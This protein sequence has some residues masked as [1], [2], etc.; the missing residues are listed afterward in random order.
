MA[1]K[2]T[3]SIIKSC[4]IWSFMVLERTRTFSMLLRLA[5]YSE[6]QAASFITMTSTEHNVWWFYLYWSPR[7]WWNLM[8]K[9][10]TLDITEWCRISSIFIL[11]RKG[12]SSANTLSIAISVIL[13]ETETK[14]QSVLSSLFRRRSSLC[15][16]SLWIS[17]WD[18]PTYL[19]KIL[20]GQSRLITVTIRYSQSP[21]SPRN[22]YC[23][24]QA[25]QPTPPQTRV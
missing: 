21:T 12:I 1:I 14:D 11:N 2:P 10:I 7:S 3:I 4:R 16:S 6:S 5:T 23:W 20:C 17:S 18:C 13:I 25:T 22:I 9:S 15:I 24:Y 19:L 8:I